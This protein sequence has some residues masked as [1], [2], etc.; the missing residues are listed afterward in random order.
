MN[1]YFLPAHTIFGGIK[2]GVQFAQLLT[3]LSAPC[4]VATPDGE[5]PDWFDASVPVLSQA[6]ALERIESSDWILFSLPHDYA[7]LLA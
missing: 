3:D 1:Y 4:A 7:R 5:A 2:A 6:Q